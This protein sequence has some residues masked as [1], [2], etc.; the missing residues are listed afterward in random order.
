VRDLEEEGKYVFFA[1]RN[2]TVKK[3]P[4]K[5]FS[6]P[7]SRG[8]IAIGIEK[9][10]ELVAADMT[11][12][13]QIVFLASH[14]GMAIRFDEDDVRPMG[15]P[16]FGVRGMDLD[17]GDYIVGMAVTPKRAPAAAAGNG[18]KNGK[19]KK[20]NGEAAETEAQPDK[21]LSITENGYG[22]RT[23][24]DEY[25]LQSRGGKGVINVKTTARNGKVVSILLVSEDSEAMVISQFGQ[26]IR[27]NS[28]GIRESG[29]NAQGVRLLSLDPGDR[30]AAAVVIPEKDEEPNG[31]LIQ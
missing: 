31:S 12:G 24:V 20:E 16:A 19:A 18:K 22:K 8:I 28:E 26:I 15:R 30:V 9:N 4:L 25:R 7:M 5:D 11:D 14:E 27:M 3:V 21:I 10:D 23:P 13:E 1:T 29:R 2:G 17:S 6:N